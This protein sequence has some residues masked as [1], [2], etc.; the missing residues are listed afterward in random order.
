MIYAEFT[1]RTEQLES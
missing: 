1:C